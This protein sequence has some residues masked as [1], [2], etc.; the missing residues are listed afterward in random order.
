MS[1]VLK[2]GHKVAI[3]L[4]DNWPYDLIVLRNGSLERVQC[5]YTESDGKCVKARC[6]SSSE[7]VQYKYTAEQIDWLAV[8]DKT[9]DTC[10]YIPSKLLGSGKRSLSLRLKPPKNNQTKGVRMAKNF[11]KF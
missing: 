3:P 11:T 10:Y 1:D 2:R 4:G 9:T 6:M 5:K 7:W 8:Y